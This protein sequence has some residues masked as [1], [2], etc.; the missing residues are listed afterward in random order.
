MITF[1]G[2]VV[3]NAGAIYRYR[4]GFYMPFV[5]LGIMSGYY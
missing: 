3:S 1:Y 2:L 5:G 4:Y